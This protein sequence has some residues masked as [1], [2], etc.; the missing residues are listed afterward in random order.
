MQFFFT[1]F[2]KLTKDTAINHFYF[3]IYYTHMHVSVY[4]VKQQQIDLEKEEKKLCT[5]ER[6]SSFLDRLKHD[7][8]LK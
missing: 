6:K 7:A 4:F 8:I 3:F 5:N 2:A 1:Y